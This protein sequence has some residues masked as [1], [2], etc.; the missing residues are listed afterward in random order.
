MVSS[1]MLK[2]DD[3][4]DNEHISRYKQKTGY[5]CK[6][7]FRVCRSQAISMTSKLFRQ[8]ENYLYELKLQDTRFQ[9]IYMKTILNTDPASCLL[10]VEKFTNHNI[11]A[12][13]NLS[14]R[15]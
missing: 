4:K 11:Q 8:I 3:I 5:I 1:T 9:D 15:S 12:L 2:E 6:E 13:L 7:T 14:S 10:L